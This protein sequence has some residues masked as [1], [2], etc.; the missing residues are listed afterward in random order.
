[1]WFEILCGLVIYKVVRLFCGD[2][3]AFEVETS[4]SDAIFSVASRLEKLYGGK[5]YIGLRIPDAD[6]GSR[7]HVDL[8]IVS[9]GE[10]VVVSVK[11]LAGIVTVNSDGSWNC[12]RENKRKEEPLED[13]VIEVGKQA[14]VLEEYLE[15]RGIALP[16]GYLSCKVLLPNPKFRCMN[17]DHFPPE[18]ITHDQWVQMKPESRGMLTGWIKGAFKGGK[19]EMQESIQQQLNFILGTAPMWDRLELR[20]S[21]HLLGEFLEFKGKSEDVQALQYIKR[22]KV[23]SLTI[24]KTSMLGFAP[25]RLQVVYSLRDYRAEGGAS[26]SSEHKEVNVRSSTVI[27]FQPRNSK[28]FRKFK[29]SSVSSMILSA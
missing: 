21:K 1:M 25:S 11:N 26:S 14:A 9:K 16:K 4:D 24:Q 28:K 20:G 23:G 19:K 17:K 5:V 10:I 15:R 3:D 7:Q 18:V 22:S 29:L 6:S 27:V 2:D 12:L 13:P 8:V